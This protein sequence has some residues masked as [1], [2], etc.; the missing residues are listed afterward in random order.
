M[1]SLRD[2]KSGKILT[3]EYKSLISIVESTIETYYLQNKKEG[4]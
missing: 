2:V 1:I 3:V 4:N